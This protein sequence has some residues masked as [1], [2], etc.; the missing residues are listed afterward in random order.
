MAAGQRDGVQLACGMPV[1]RRCSSP[2]NKSQRPAATISWRNRETVSLS[3]GGESTVESLRQRRLLTGSL[4]LKV[5]PWRQ[6]P[7]AWS[8]VSTVH[9]LSVSE[10]SGTR[11][12]R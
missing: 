6:A 9:H 5:A 11:S 8:L 3:E 12:G 7:P 4:R 10:V 1:Q 2:R